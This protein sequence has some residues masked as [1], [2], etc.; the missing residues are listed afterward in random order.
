M[1]CRTSHLS[2]RMIWRKV[3]VKAHPF[4]EGCGLVWCEQDDHPFFWS[5]HSAKRPFFYIHTFLQIILCFKSVV[6]HGIEWIPSPKQ[7]RRLLP[8]LLSVSSS[9]WWSK[10]SNLAGGQPMRRLAARGL[11]EDPSRLEH[12]A[13]R[14]SAGSSAVVV[15]GLRPA[16]GRSDSLG[17]HRSQL[18]NPWAQLLPLLGSRSRQMKVQKPNCLRISVYYYCYTVS[19]TQFVLKLHGSGWFRHLAAGFRI[20]SDAFHLAGS[21]INHWSDIVF[22]H[23]K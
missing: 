10:V 15:V 13:L 12:L 4:W 8:S 2:A 14:L 21:I 19:L 9:I 22:E 6:R 5:I 23:L 16:L 7:Q 18:R 11:V 3:F 17:Q 1:K 20:R